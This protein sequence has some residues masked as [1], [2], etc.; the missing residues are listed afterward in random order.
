MRWPMLTRSPAASR[1]AFLRMLAGWC[2]GLVASPAIAKGR[3]PSRPAPPAPGEQNPYQQALNAVLQGQTW[4]PSPAVTLEVP[5]MAENGAIMPI[6]LESQ[7]PGTRRLLLF[8]EQ[9]PGPLLAEFHFAP[10]ADPWIS[11]RVKLN[12]TGPLLALAEADGRFY[13]VETVVKVM[14]GGCG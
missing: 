12:A 2:A 13:G 9:N 10:G 8:A 1:R 7:M 6:T 3:K 14:V 5:A 4:Q 11:L